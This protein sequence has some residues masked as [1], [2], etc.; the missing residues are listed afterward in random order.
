LKTGKF[1]IKTGKF[2]KTGDRLM[3][4]KGSFLDES[5]VRKII[6][7]LSTTEMTIADISERMGC[8]RGVVSGINT[9]YQIRKDAGRGDKSTAQNEKFHSRQRPMTPAGLFFVV[10]GGD[11]RDRQAAMTKAQI[12]QLADYANQ[13]IAGG[14]TIS[15]DGESMGSSADVVAKLSCLD[16]VDTK[17]ALWHLW[18]IVRTMEERK[19]PL[20]EEPKHKPD[21]LIT[22]KDDCVLH[23]IGVK[24]WRQ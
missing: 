7:L 16:T 20:Q 2:D 3:A 12:E 5:E 22:M 19:L 18:S 4:R 10:Q 24:K 13:I 9:K 15:I 6:L 17:S 14:G 1:L 23:D 11:D 21:V 8:S